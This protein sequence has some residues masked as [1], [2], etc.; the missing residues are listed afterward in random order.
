MA[1]DEQYTPVSLFAYLGVTFDLDVA[2]PKGGIHYIP[3]LAHY[4]KEDDGLKQPWSGM[5]WMNPPYSKPS[6]WVDKFIAHGN[7][8]A[9][10]PMSKSAWSRK[11]W[12]AAD[13]I[14][15]VGTMKFVQADGKSSQI[16]MPVLLY[17]IGH[18]ATEAIKRVNYGRVR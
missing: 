4:S 2:A 11:L 5:V 14:S 8:I 17:S 1:N 10:L 3:A 13:G 15:Y 7:G 16:Y 6:P 18:E 9:L 12:D